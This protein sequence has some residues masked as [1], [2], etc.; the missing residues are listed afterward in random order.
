MASTGA[1]FL[2]QVMNAL[3]TEGGQVIALIDETFTDMTDI[4]LL[5][6][7]ASDSVLDSVGI[8]RLVS[9]TR[10]ADVEQDPVFGHIPFVTKPLRSESLH[11][12]LLSLLDH[13]Y[14]PSPRPNT[15]P[16]LPPCLSGNV[17]VGEDNPVN[18]EIALLMLESLGCT[19][20]IAQTGQELLATAQKTRYDLILMDCQMPEMDGFEATRRIREWESVIGDGNSRHPIPIIALTAHATPRDR[21][22]CLA[23]GMSDYLSKPFTIEGLQQMLVS[24]LPPR[25]TAQSLEQTQLEQAT[26]PLK[27]KTREEASSAIDRN[28]WN[29]ITALQRPGQPDILAKILSLYLVDSQQLVDKLRR[30]LTTSEARLVDEAMHSLKSR[31]AVLGAISLSDLCRQIEEMS[32]QGSLVKAEPLL[33]PLEAAFADACRVFQAELDKREC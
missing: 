10:R 30:G 28:A 16:A 26:H 2:E 6:A 8:L 32:R 22:N 17:L 1:E 5:R 33:E 18:Q 24:W 23:A 3:A 14:I 20:T 11:Q 4:Q 29:S 27:V 12:T 9:F 19:A 7:L 15:T 21:E 13:R 25:P 31:S